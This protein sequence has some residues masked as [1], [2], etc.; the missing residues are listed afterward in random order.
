M[1]NN[2]KCLR[3]MPPN[4][5]Q[6]SPLDLTFIRSLLTEVRDLSIEWWGQRQDWGDSKGEWCVKERE[7]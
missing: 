4:E 7:P 6:K 1:F 3:E 5:A 2:I